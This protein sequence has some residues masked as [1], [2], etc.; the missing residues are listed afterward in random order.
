MPDINYITRRW[1]SAKLLARYVLYLVRKDEGSFSFI[2]DNWYAS[3]EC[4]LFWKIFLLSLLRR[5][6]RLPYEF[7]RPCRGDW[8]G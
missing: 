1:W 8:L 6:Y 4:R 7:L 5:G 3:Q 2:P